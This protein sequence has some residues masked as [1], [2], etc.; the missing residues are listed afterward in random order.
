MYCIATVHKCARIIMQADIGS[1]AAPAFNKS[2]ISHSTGRDVTI[3]SELRNLADAKAKRAGFQAPANKR[4]VICLLVSS[5]VTAAQLLLKQPNLSF[6]AIC[7]CTSTQ[8]RC[9]VSSMRVNRDVASQ[10]LCRSRLKCL[11][12]PCRISTIRD[13]SVPSTK[14]RGCKE[15]TKRL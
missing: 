3:L 10:S 13:M 9:T 2:L 12:V 15:L 11:V 1:Q 6:T 5:Y 7:L 8:M 14:E 4:S